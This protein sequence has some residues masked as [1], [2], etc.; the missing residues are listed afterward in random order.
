MIQ[1]GSFLWM[2]VIFISV[3]AVGY[4]NAE[5]MK[6]EK[7][8]EIEMVSG[9]NKD[10][11]VRAES[12]KVSTGATIGLHIEVINP[13]TDKNLVLIV[14]DDIS[15]LFNVRLINAEG[16]DISPMQKIMMTDKRGPTSSK[17]YRYDTILPRASHSW[18]ISIPKQI[19]ADLTRPSSENNL[20]PIPKGKYMA[21][22]QVIVEYSTQDKGE[23]PISTYSNFQT[24]RLTLPRLPISIDPALLNQ[25][26]IKIYTESGVKNTSEP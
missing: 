23:E 9:N 8:T 7:K 24:L 4:C 15:F 2:T 18:F 6:G 20:Q 12:I 1:K 11:I 10:V 26:I 3:V 5:P 17:T 19:R 13:S 22:I 16:I 14:R 21:E 25:D